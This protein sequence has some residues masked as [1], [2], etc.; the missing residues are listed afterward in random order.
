MH[1][2]LPTRAKLSN[3]SW[4][5]VVEDSSCDNDLLSLD[6]VD[7]DVDDTDT[8]G[9]GVDGRAAMFV[10]VDDAKNDEVILAGKVERFRRLNRDVDNVDNG[11]DDNNG[12]E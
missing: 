2:F 4:G 8:D 3:L 7:V 12:N 11:D 9:D 6:D 10:C 5:N 1:Y